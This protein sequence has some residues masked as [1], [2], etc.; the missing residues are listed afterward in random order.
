MVDSEFYDLCPDAASSHGKLVHF[1]GDFS[2]PTIEE[3]VGK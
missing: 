3:L 1:N 2:F